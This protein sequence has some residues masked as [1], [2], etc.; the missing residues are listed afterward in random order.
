MAMAAGGPNGGGGGKMVSLRLQYY[1]VFAAV[2]VAVIV[3]SLTFLSPSAMGAVRQ[4][5]GTVVANSGAGERQ[6]RQAVAAV[7]AKPEPEPEAEKVEEK[8]EPPVVLFNFGDS[9]SDTGGVAAAGGINIM[10]P[11]GRTYFGHPTGRLSD[12]R[13]IIDFICE[14]LNHHIHHPSAGGAAIIIRT[15]RRSESAI[16]NSTYLL[17]IRCSSSIPNHHMNQYSCVS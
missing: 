14:L 3:L 16:P 2:G 1:C 17:V 7:V 13:V 4:N 8:K 9:N 12:G 15:S 5:L 6:A 11:K 10:P